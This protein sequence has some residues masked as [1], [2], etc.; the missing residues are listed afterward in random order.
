MKPRI[1]E[2]ALPVNN[3]VEEDT[4]QHVASYIPLA[5][6]IYVCHMFD[7]KPSLCS[8]PPDSED[9]L[10]TYPPGTDSSSKG[11]IFLAA[12]GVPLHITS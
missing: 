1:T 4:S 2:L 3:D 5:V 12:Q 8:S 11:W 7:V 6:Y 9:I 10:W